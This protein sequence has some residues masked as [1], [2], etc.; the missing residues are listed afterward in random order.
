MK[1]IQRRFNLNAA[2]IAGALYLT[3]AVL[4]GFSIMYVP[5]EIINLA[6]PEATIKNLTSQQSLFRLG[7][8]ADILTF[9]IEIVLTMILYQLFKGVNK[10]LA[11]IAILA[12]FAMIIIMG[13]NLVVYTT[14]LFMV[15]NPA[16]SALFDQ[17]QMNATIMLLFNMHQNMILLWGLFFGFHVLILGFLVYASG[18]YPKLLGSLLLI[19]SFGYLLESFA[20]FALPANTTISAIVVGL[21]IVVVIGELSFAFWLLIKGATSKVAVAMI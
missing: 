17:D 11:R 18:D 19:G 14:P 12:R 2:K 10:T 5:G 1:T 21:L 8:A 9:M 13:I 3:I 15:S 16:L 7:V 4:G 20:H 6:D